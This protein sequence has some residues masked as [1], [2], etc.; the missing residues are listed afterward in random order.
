MITY[1]LRRDFI[2]TILLSTKILIDI[3]CTRHAFIL[4]S[5]P[6][7]NANYMSQ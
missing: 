7:V 2:P 5:I 4:Y 3:E 1:K 6:N